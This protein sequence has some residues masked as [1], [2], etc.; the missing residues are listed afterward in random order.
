MK[1]RNSYQFK[2]LFYKNLALQSRHIGTNMCQI[3]T[4]LIC[5]F[6]VQLIKE[7]AFDKFQGSTFKI[8]FPYL[9]NV[10][11]LY[12]FFPNLLEL[13]CLQW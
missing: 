2:A 4:P 12:N 8:D 9:F 1:K 6:F 3:I 5:L 11:A 7:L 10:P 13:N